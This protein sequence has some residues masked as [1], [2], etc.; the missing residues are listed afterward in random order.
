MK[1]IIISVIIGLSLILSSLIL[2]TKDARV[3][4]KGV[5]QLFG[6]T[7]VVYKI[8]TRTGQTEILIPADNAVGFVDIGDIN[9]ENLEVMKENMKSISQY[10]R[11][12]REKEA[13]PIK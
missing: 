5:Y 12:E 10:I 7:G 8:N 9:F 13:A 4:E 3:L 11:S 2:R 1:N 6:H